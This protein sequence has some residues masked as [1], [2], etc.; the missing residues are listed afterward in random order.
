MFLL[1]SYS[2]RL[3]FPKAFISPMYDW[4]QLFLI[5]CFGR[6]KLLPRSAF[7]ESCPEV[8]LL[9][10]VETFIHTL[11]VSFTLPTTWI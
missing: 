11:S 4:N 3:R 8:A 10:K 6:R 2:T 7:P 9:K 1:C 5:G